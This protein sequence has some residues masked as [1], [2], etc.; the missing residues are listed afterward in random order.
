MKRITLFVA[1]VCIAVAAIAQSVGLSERIFKVKPSP[2]IRGANVKVVCGRL[3]LDRTAV[4]HWQILG[5]A[6]RTIDT[7]S[8]VLDRPMLRAWM[9]SDEPVLWLRTNVLNAVQLESND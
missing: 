7:G 5:A 4:I 1:L 8:I 6:G 2:D 9:N 3:Y